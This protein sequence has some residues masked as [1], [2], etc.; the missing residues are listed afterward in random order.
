M[1]LIPITE[2]R[3]DLV[4][5][6]M[7][8]AFPFEERRYISDQKECLNNKFFKF[9]EI[10][11]NE[12]DVGFIALWDFPEFVFIEHI[13]I[14]EEVRA[15]GYG[16]K[17]IE[18]VKETYKKAIILEA[19]APET[20]QQIKRIRFYDRLGFKINSYDYEQPSY[21]SGEGVPLKILSFPELLNQ[22]E[23]DL[24]IKRTRENGYKGLVQELSDDEKIDVV[25]KKILDKYLPAFEELAK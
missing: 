3:F 20:E 5:S 18:L 22:A 15:G 19:E 24:F 25:A 21:H 4:F 6:K 1:K 2:E 23:F 11:D 12:T 16:S 7:I 13:A 10:F 17:T 8:A 14:D 9:F